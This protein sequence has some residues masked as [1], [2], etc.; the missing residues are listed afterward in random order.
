MSNSL[1]TDQI[2]YNGVISSEGFSKL[3]EENQRIFLEGLANSMGKEGG[4]FGKFFG[5]KKENASMNIAFVICLLLIILCAI[6]IIH[7]VLNDASAYTEL[8][9]NVLPVISLSLGF[10]FGKGEK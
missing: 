7:A 6:D 10:I 2:S 4:F 1:N 5:T 9:K 3:S 8:T